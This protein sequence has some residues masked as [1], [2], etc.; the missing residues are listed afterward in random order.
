MADTPEQP[1]YPGAARV[2]AKIEELHLGSFQRHIFLCV[3]GDC[4]PPKLQQESWKFLKTR[5]KEL[6]LVDADG[7]V[8][9][10]KAECLR[11]CM[12]GPVAVVYPEGTWYRKCTPANLERVIQ[13]H[14]I[15]GTPVAD[16]VIATNSLGPD[17]PDAT[18]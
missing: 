3:G 7:G 1:S 17:S 18:S 4:A 13:E 11:L 16:L 14:L 2:A 10:T 5:L 8:F 9:R 12:Q 15:G 6:G